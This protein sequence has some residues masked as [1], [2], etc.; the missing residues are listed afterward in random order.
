MPAGVHAANHHDEKKVFKRVEVRDLQVPLWPELSIARIWV[1]AIRLPGFADH[2]PSE[3]KDGNG[4]DRVFFFRILSTLAPDFLVTLIE[5]C[6]RQ[7]T[8]KAMAQEQLVKPVAATD[9]WL[10]L[11]ME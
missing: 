2:V 4:V 11:L 5:D 9:K 8:N 3:W 6:R 1:E 10:K 7:R